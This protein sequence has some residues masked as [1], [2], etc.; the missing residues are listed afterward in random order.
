MESKNH[1]I[2]RRIL[3]RLGEG[4]VVGIGVAIVLGGYDAM[5]KATDE[6]R[7]TR[8]VLEKQVEINQKLKDQIELRDQKL[9]QVHDLMNETNLL[10]DRVASLASRLRAVET[11]S[12]FDSENPL[13]AGDF[14]WKQFEAL[15]RM[16]LSD[17][18]KF[19]EIN[20][21][22]LESLQDAINAQ[23]TVQRN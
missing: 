20:E 5:S 15:E 18:A 22:M 14:D 8:S 16:S 21:S 23:R 13:N 19:E 11:A 3:T 12:S 9:S 1:G 7:K 17:S 10:A 2:F 4:V 6:L